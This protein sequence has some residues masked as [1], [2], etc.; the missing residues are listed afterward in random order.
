MRIMHIKRTIR[1][2]SDE[3]KDLFLKSTNRFRISN[4]IIELI[5]LNNSGWKKRVSEIF[6]F[7]IKKRDVVMVSGSPC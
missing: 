4:I 5:L 6:M 7:N 3:F 2:W 1:T